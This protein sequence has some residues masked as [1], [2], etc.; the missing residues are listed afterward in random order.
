MIIDEEVFAVL[1]AISVVGS[2]IGIATVL[3]P[4]TV[5]PFT[6]IGLLSASCQIGDYPTKAFNNSALSLCIFVLNHMGK[7]VLYRVVYKVGD[8]ETLPTNAT[9]SPAREAMA[10]IGVLGNKQNATTSIEVPVYANGPLPTKVA[11]IFELWL[12]DTELNRWV[13]TG[14]WV[15]LYVDV[16]PQIA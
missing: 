15:H 12:Y 5:E 6:A 10:W 11:L 7:P 9:P 2:V 1:I 4:E 8:L 13:Y 3:R 14:R 16:S